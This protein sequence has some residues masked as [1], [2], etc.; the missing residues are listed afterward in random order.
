MRAGAA[1][2][3]A[4]DDDD[5]IDDGIDEGIDEDDDDD[6]DDDDEEAAGDVGVITGCLALGNRCMSG[7]AMASLQMASCSKC[8]SGW[9]DSAEVLRREILEKSIFSA[10]DGAKC[11]LQKP[12]DWT[13]TPVKM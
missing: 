7:C 5:G 3:D 4:D 12:E 9:M 2:A 6:D 8:E 11:P 10:F 13:G 1:P